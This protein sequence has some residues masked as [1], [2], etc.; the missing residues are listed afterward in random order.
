MDAPARAR[1]RWAWFC[2]RCGA[3]NP[4]AA[5]KCE[6]CDLDH[7]LLNASG[8]SLS[9]ACGVASPGWAAYCIGCGDELAD[10]AIEEP[11]E[12]AARAPAPAPRVRTADLPRLRRPHR[13]LPSSDGPPEGLTLTRHV[14]L[15]RT[16]GRTDRPEPFRLLAILLVA[17]LALGLLVRVLAT[18]G[19]GAFAFVRAYRLPGQ[20][21]DGLAVLEGLHRLLAPA[22]T[23]PSWAIRVERVELARPNGQPRLLAVR[24][25]VRNSGSSSGTLNP[26]D[27]R[28]VD[29]NGLDLP[30]GEASTALARAAGLAPLGQPIAAGS[31][32]ST[33]LVFELTGEPREPRLKLP[34][35]EAALQIPSG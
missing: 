13:I 28:L 6:E 18:P 32:S 29:A 17:A 12:E 7:K 23:P 3:H 1:W 26:A 11:E 4:A 20:A 21:F 34:G 10:Q 30:A 35:A 27:V 25:A 9:H 15:E 24:A 2:P 8:P 19:D 5:E 33:L 16:A 22:P 31:E 14:L